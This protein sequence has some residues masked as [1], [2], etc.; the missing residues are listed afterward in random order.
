MIIIYLEGVLVSLFMAFAIIAIGKSKGLVV[1]D[2]W[3]TFFLLSLMSWFTV[4]LLCLFAIYLIV[5]GD[6][7]E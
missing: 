6:K 4:T 5:I 7:S 3:Y 2:V 1:K